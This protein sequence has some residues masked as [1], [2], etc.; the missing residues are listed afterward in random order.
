MPRKKKIQLTLESV[1]SDAHAYAMERHYECITPEMFVYHVLDNWCKIEQ[2]FYYEDVMGE[3][4]Y[5]INETMEELPEAPD[6]ES[7]ELSY[8]LGECF[9]RA[10]E[11][12]K[13]LEAKDLTAT[14]VLCEILCTDECWANFFLREHLEDL[15]GFLADLNML[16]GE[17]PYNDEEIDRYHQ[18][19]QAREGILDFAQE[20]GKHFN[21]MAEQVSGEMGDHQSGEG[22]KKK[23]EDWRQWVTCVNEHLE[24]RNPL[25]GR[26]DELER[27]IRVL[28]RRDKNNPLHVGD[29]GVGKTALIY[30]LA[31]KIKAGEVPERLKDAQIFSLD[32]STLLA[33]TQYRG[34]FEKRW[35]LIMEGLLTVPNAIVYIDEIHTIVGA[36]RTSDGAMDAA[37]MLKPF[38]EE[39]RIRFV[40]A[41]THE[42][43]NRH[44]AG[45]GALV[46][47]FQTI[48]VPEPSI[49]EAV[50]I[51]EGL[52]SRYESFHNVTFAPDAVRHAVHRA[53]RFI[54]DRRLPDK[55]I[56]LID[57]AAAYREVHPA[58][59]QVVSKAL[60]DQVLAGI[61]KVESLR[62]VETSEVA[63]LQSLEPAMKRQIF[64]Q[65]EAIAAVTE[66]VLLSR[67]GLTDEHKP[68]ASLLFVGPTGVGK[69]EVAKVLAE[70]MGVELLRFD[71]SEY[72]EKH[73][74]ARLI[75]APAGYVG[76]E[77]GGLLTDA[78]RRTPHCVLLL[79]E[80][81]KAHPD[82][83][84]LLLQV[85]DNAS[86]TDTRGRQADFRHAVVVMTSNAGAQHAHQAAVGFGGGVSAGQ[87]M[88]AQVKRTFKPEFLN[89]LSATVVFN[90]MNTE[91]AHLILRK[92][93]DALRGKLLARR[94]ELVLSP[95]AES[96]LLNLG[97][98]P[99]YGA[100][101]IERI[102]ARELKPLLTRS[103][104]FGDL[105]HGGEAKVDVAAE[106]LVLSTTPLAP[107]AEPA[108][109]APEKAVLSASKEE[110]TPAKKAARSTTRK[111]TKKTTKKSDE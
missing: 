70:E 54:N 100:R 17:T 102:V 74:V 53:A 1:I 97:Y 43:F 42:E 12:Q 99:E 103:L 13:K 109:S 32:V 65:D 35:K 107:P 28:C 31:E 108:E 94:V 67:A 47:R 95:E 101:E 82:I 5:Y 21:E 23:G 85:M 96:H 15:H 106:K 88:L 104:L 90:A 61:C 69:T 33:G 62:D 98:T 83:F 49:D 73:T 14:H 55:A 80:I 29:P 110:K 63:D 50:R 8:Q 81:E 26:E 76:Y 18:F 4:L 68:V 41:T 22:A 89:R 40:G 39:G 79:D 10:Q 27:T 11:M 3:L 86:L 92:K 45:H 34:D 87:A 9:L 7:I 24:N 111:T 58:E 36:G 44:I 91:M 105:K 52:Q 84:N 60:I 71:M 20:L 56:D 51:L 66:A 6:E 38:L 78:V 77:D 37:N 59:N 57:E 72:A 93:V 30:G 46:R 75:G 64:G 2:D 19:V 25:I 48:E 16:C